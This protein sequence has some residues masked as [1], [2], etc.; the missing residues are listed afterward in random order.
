[1][2]TI[3]TTC[4]NNI[5]PYQIFNKKETENF[6]KPKVLLVKDEL[7]NQKVIKSILEALG[8]Q[9]DIAENG[10]KALKMHQNDYQAILMDFDLP[11]MNGSEIYSQIRNLEHNIPIIALIAQ[12][13]PN[14]RSICLSSGMNEFTTKP[15]NLES[16]KKS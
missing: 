11:D 16:L 8:Y 12:N 10:I 2:Q 13:D 4:L 6:I 15:I 3:Q 1:M 9:I 5:F 14:V 7:I